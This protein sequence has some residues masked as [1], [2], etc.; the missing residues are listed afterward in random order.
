VTADADTAPQRTAGAAPVV[1]A[2]GPARLEG[3]GS[4]EAQLAKANPPPAPKDKLEEDRRSVVVERARSDL[5]LSQV[6]GYGALGLMAVQLAVADTGFLFHGLWNHWKVPAAAIEI[7]L[8]A[9]VVQVIGVVLLITKYLFPA[10]GGV[11]AT[12]TS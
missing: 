6:V 10:S 12:T 11:D 1:S 7:W 2:A 8:G 5:V 4:V 9:I 3:P